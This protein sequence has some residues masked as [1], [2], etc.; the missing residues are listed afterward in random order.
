MHHSKLNLIT[1]QC[2]ETRLSLEDLTWLCRRIQSPSNRSWSPIT[3]SPSHRPHKFIHRPIDLEHLLA[4]SSYP[5]YSMQRLCNPRPPRHR[6]NKTRSRRTSHHW[7]YWR[8]YN[9]RL[10]VQ[11]HHRQ[12]SMVAHPNFLSMGFPIMELIRA[13]CNIRHIRD[14]VRGRFW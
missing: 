1:I 7:I 13:H 14:R 2:K 6:P 3:H 10:L 11:R 5:R 4:V 8:L 12:L 9:M